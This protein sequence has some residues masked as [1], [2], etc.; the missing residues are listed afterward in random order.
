[1]SQDLAIEPRQ[2]YAARS[3]GYRGGRVRGG[4]LPLLAGLCLLIWLPAVQAVATYEDSTKR[5][6]IPVVEVPGLGNFQVG[7]VLDGAEFVLTD[8]V[9]I[10]VGSGGDGEEPSVYSLAEEILHIP[11]VNVILSGGVV[12]P[13]SAELTLVP[14]SDPMR[15]VLTAA[16]ELPMDTAEPVASDTPLPT[17]TSEPTVTPG[18]KT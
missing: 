12:V 13:Y 14:L 1:M 8:A 9:E 15:F 4:L 18:G 6:E 2:R 11:L 16:T 7:M 10:A 17:D 5:L 3:N